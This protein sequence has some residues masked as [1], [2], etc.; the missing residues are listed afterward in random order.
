VAFGVMP[1]F[2]LANAGVQFGGVDLSA[3]GPATVALGVM[4]ALV[5]GKPVGVLL[6]TFVAVRLRLC[7]MPQGVTWPGV[8]LVGMLAGI[9]FTMAI[10]VGGLAFSQPELLAAAKMGI[11][12]A[13]GAA[14][15]LGLLYGF[16]MRKRLGATEAA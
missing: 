12:G 1:I 6:A 2:A 11:L 15:L 3:S 13:S 7:T 5:L 16:A 14:A 8:L 9:G 4:V 10:F